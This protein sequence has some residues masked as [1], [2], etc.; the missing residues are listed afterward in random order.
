M[1]KFNKL[2]NIRVIK[3]RHNKAMEY[4]KDNNK[5]LT[6]EIRQ[7]IDEYWRL[8]EKEDKNE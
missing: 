8:Y 6:N 3:E 1:R 5:S 2:I 7:L 4:C